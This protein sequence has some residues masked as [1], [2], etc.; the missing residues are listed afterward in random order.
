MGQTSRGEQ[1]YLTV[2]C[3][4]CG[5]R[6]DEVVRDQPRTVRCPDCHTGVPVPARAQIPVP[7]V[8]RPLPEVGTYRIQSEVAADPA[9]KS[10]AAERQARR[11]RAMVLV[12]CPLCSARIDTLAGKQSRAVKCP[13]CF[14][15]VRVP[16]F[17][18][19]AAKRKS[20]PPVV[21][22]SVEPLPV[23]TPDAR[24]GEV[25]T[26]FA[27]AR[28]HIRRDAD[29]PPPRRVFL[30]GVFGLP[31]QVEVFPRWA[32]LSFGLVVMNL[33]IAFLVTGG[34]QTAGSQF[35]MVIA[36]FVLPLFWVGTW[37]LSYAAAC[38]R[39]ILEDTA[40]GN[41]RIVSWHEQNWREWVLVLV[42]VGYLAG[43]TF[44]VA[45]LVARVLE[46]AGVPYLPPLLTIGWVAF[47]FV[48]LSS[49]EADSLLVPLSVPV[50][51]SL[52][53]HPGGWLVFSLVSTIVVTGPLLLLTLLLR[54]APYLLALVGS[55]LLA[56]S[57]FVYARLLGRLGWLISQPDRR[58][59]KKRQRRPA[60]S[61]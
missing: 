36:F 13:D 51:R 46:L 23:P 42:W 15:L 37:T 19:V 14:E 12:I 61:F 24:S 58:P 8:P 35:G 54:D 4:V 50:L 45:H 10:A 43:V 55:P 6:L 59:A 52:W 49:L 20:Q 7:A 33:L 1:Q 60:A 11:D 48:L 22:T 21:A 53:R 26:F 34:L 5:T 29:A 38:C 18:E 40:A 31:W 57:L 41:R 47:P 3:P 28:A 2:V 56:A 9:A 30:S 44:V 27:D 17:Q 39:A 16:S 32:F 25:P